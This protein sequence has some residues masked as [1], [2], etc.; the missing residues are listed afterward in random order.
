MTDFIAYFRNLAAT[1]AEIKHTN[2]EPHFYRFELDEVLSHL[3]S[4]INYPA[5]VLEGYDY[6]FEDNRSDNVMKHRN[7]AFMILTEIADSTD[8]DAKAEK[9][10][11]CESIGDDILRRINKDKLTFP[12]LRSFD[13]NKVEAN[14]IDGTSKT[15]G[16]RFAF[17]LPGKFLKDVDSSKWTDLE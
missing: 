16:W 10:D 15:I 5:L 1:H 2:K 8:F 11:L 9:Y 17:P 6:S 3:P 14:M 12:I 7:A 4:G 13:F